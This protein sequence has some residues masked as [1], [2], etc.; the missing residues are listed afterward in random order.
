MCATYY[1]SQQLKRMCAA[2]PSRIDF[3]NKYQEIIKEY[4]EAQNKAEIENIFQ[5]LVDLAAKLSE[6]ETRVVREGF[7]SQE[8][9]AIFDRIKTE[10]LS[11]EDIQKV[12]KTSIDLLKKVRDV[13]ASMDHWTDKEETQANVF[14][15]IRDVLAEELPESY[16]WDFINMCKERVY[17][18]VYTRYANAAA[19]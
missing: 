15:C 17:D 12:K 19:V 6:E 7:S 8:E 4:N 10:N 5:E 16:D 9:L 2:N 18:Y 13:I 14:V 11:K 1:R 3:Y